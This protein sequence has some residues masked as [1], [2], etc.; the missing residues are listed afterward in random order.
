MTT[1]QTQSSIRSPVDENRG[2]LLRLALKLDAVASSALGILSLGASPALDDLLGTPLAL[3]VTVG[4]S[5]SPGRRRC[6]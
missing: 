6:G 5:W 3:L 4:C 2:G 1:H